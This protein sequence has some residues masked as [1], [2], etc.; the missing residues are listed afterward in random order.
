MKRK[1][2]GDSI[3]LVNLVM[4]NQITYSYLALIGNMQQSLP[5]MPKNTMWA[6]HS[7]NA[8][9]IP[10]EQSLH[11]M[12]KEY[13]VTNYT[14]YSIKPGGKFQ[15]LI[16]ISRLLFWP[17]Q[18]QGWN[19]TLCLIGALTFYSFMIFLTMAPVIW[20]TLQITRL[21]RIQQSS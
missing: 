12:T 10:C 1:I 21:K 13:H 11:H 18:T 4:V 6:K 20:V 14:V 7:S 16:L 3:Q 9:R 2:C 17:A 15:S 19:I 5:H 8:K